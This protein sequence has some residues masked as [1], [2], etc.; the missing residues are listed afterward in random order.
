MR[1]ALVPILL[2]LACAGCAGDMGFSRKP[3]PP[4]DPH[5]QMAALED[6]VFTLIEQERVKIDPAAKTL[7]LDS[8]LVGVAREKSADMATK[9]Y[10]AHKSPD[11][12]TTA[13][14]IMDKDQ[15]F[16]GLLGENIAA[17][18]YDPKYGIDVETYAHAIVNTWLGSAD[19]KQNLSYAP[20]NRAGVGA[21]VNDGMVYVTQLFATDMGLPPPEQQHAVRPIQQFADPKTAGNASKPPPGAKLLTEPR[22]KP[23]Q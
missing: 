17:E 2:L 23:D 10:L 12:Q 16:Q 19:H 3:A 22:P 9:N 11:G 6:R 21:A 4:P 13:D 14:I 5:T 18:G 7:A 1:K 15:D 20:Y 8:E